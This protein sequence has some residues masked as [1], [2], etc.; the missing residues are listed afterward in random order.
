MER[1]FFVST[2]KFMEEKKMHKSETAHTEPKWPIQTNRL[3]I[4]ASTSALSFADVFWETTECDKRHVDNEVRARN[5]R[6]R[7]V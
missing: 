2:A 6:E 3:A 4:L 5:Q 1:L 7:H